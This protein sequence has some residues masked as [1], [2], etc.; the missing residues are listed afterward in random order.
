MSGES[1]MDG[2]QL[3]VRIALELAEQPDHASA[4]QRLTELGVK[5]L[6]CDLAAVWQLTS[7]GT[8]TLRATT[9][10]ITGQALDSILIGVDEGI[11]H[12]AL[13][14]R[15]I[16]VLSDIETEPRWPAYRAAVTARRLPIRSAVAYPLTV[17]EHDLGA[18]A[19]YSNT[20]G[21]FDDPAQRDVG[22]LLA[23]H[24]AIALETT[25]VSDKASNLQVA[26]QSNRVIGMALGILMAHH[27]LTEDGAFDLL[28]AASQRNHVK[29]R[30]LAEQVVLTGETPTWST[31]KAPA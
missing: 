15:C 4:L 30:E 2:A 25:Y 29:L 24:A 21:Y 8:T 1:T 22:T 28:R 6:S 3:F 31:T 9:D 10:A 12:E 5:L 16:V 26:L 18:L 17:A 7:G 13:A 11:A 27:Q 19:L 14:T 23:A 20:P